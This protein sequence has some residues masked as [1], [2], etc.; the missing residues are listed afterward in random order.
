MLVSKIIFRPVPFVAILVAILVAALDVTADDFIPRTQTAPPGPPLSPELAMAKMTVPDGFRVELVASE[1]ALQNPVAMAFDD[2]GRIYVTESFE[3]PRREPGP[4][5]DKIKILEDT[6]GDGKAE[7]VK[8]FAEG[9]NIPSGI[10]VGHGGVWVANAPDLL[11]LEDTDGDDVADKTTVIVTG[12]GR[13]DTHE[14]PNALTWGPDGCLYGLNGVFNRSVIK[15]DGKVFDF[16]CAM[17]RIDPITKKFDLFCEGTSNPWGIAFDGEGSAFISACVID[18]LWHLTE[19]AY[20]QRQGGP[21]PPHTWPADSIVKHKHQMAA[22]CGIEY[23]DSAA[24]PEKYRDKL[25]MGNIHGGCL[26]C[27]RVERSGATYKGFSEPDFLTA[28]DVWF[29]PVAQKVGPDG[30]M[31]VL[32][33]YDR[34]HC[35]QDANADPKGVD[36][37][38]GRLYR[39]V[40]GTRP[41]AKVKDFGKLSNTELIGLLSDDNIFNRQ[42]AQLKLQERR[43]LSQDVQSAQQLQAIVLGP[44]STP[45]HRMHALWSL[46]GSGLLP[47][48]FL[49]QLLV[50]SSPELRAWGTRI[51]GRQDSR[52]A[53]VLN[54]IHTLAIDQD[55]RVR[56]QVS[57]AA[58]KLATG[59]SGSAD[60]VGQQIAVLRASVQD[61][62]VPRVVWQNLKPQ[63]VEQ[64]VMISESILSELE[65]DQ[66]LL[67]EMSPRIATRLIADVRSDLTDE[68]SQRAC[69][70]ILKIAGGLSEKHSDLA[71]ST[72]E[73]LLAKARTGEIKIESLRPILEQW[74]LSHEAKPHFKAD[75]TN[76]DG[77]VSPWKKA[78]LSVRLLCADADAIATARAWALERKLDGALRKQMF[79][80][81]VKIQ[82]DVASEAL[83][84]L[85]KDLSQN[86][87]IDVPYRDAVLDAGIARASADDTSRLAIALPSLKS[88]IQAAIAERMCQR[89]ETAQALLA[90]IVA[91]KLRKELISPNRVRLLAKDTSES[92]RDAVKKIWGNVSAESSK[93][94]EEVIK[95]V[96]NDLRWDARGNAERGWIVYDR[97]CG[98]CH[99][100]HG[101]GVE[102]GPNITANGRGSYEQ[103]LVSVFNPSL[104]IGEA[105]KG[106]TLR[107]VDGT[108]VTGLLLERDEKRTVIRVQGG[109][110]QTIP[111]DEIEEF[112]QDKK[113]LMPEGIENQVSAQELADLFALL[114]LESPPTSKENAKISGTPDNLHSKK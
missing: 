86:S 81:V 59:Q 94:R 5:R 98:Q 83:I 63:L 17:F 95:R 51:A 35:Y 69:S 90:Q 99:L 55:P 78:L 38:H 102:V 2:R 42:R 23:F 11:F 57:I 22:Y 91:G 20:Y 13:D 37:A 74:L 52:N 43:V 29:M 40:H 104:V 71:A 108:I 103:L 96:T 113:S 87:K 47:D 54:R 8:V 60:N 110:D 33:W 1:P 4:G 15:Q 26:N 73:S 79:Q 107:T 39:I 101:R 62:I 88:D 49:I 36:R 111:N 27:D 58:P 32:D 75:Y 92:I 53:T 77:A 19:S 61:P 56:L 14:L 84:Q 34:Y 82:P 76:R 10:A 65:R 28:N 30:C 24:Y 41:P 12:F 70:S 68:S 93:E 3:Y 6:D 45:K 31:F 100:M 25:Y 105:Y 80:A 97:I 89:G 106:V 50:H 44:E 72:I 21:Y 7:T 67:R 46:T 85:I 112:K 16:T 9:L 109:K 114:T 66:D 64:Q 18:H 48:D